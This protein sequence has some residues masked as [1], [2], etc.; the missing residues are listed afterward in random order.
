MAAHRAGRLPDGLTHRTLRHYDEIGLLTPSGRTD[1][2]Y[3]LYSRD[4]LRRLLAIQNLKSL[5]LSLTEIAAALDE[6]VDASALLGRHAAVVEDRIAEEQRLL[7]TLRRLQGAADA[8]GTRCS[9][10][11]P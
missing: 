11:S 5:G 1:V 2:D 10:R 3:R 8:G 6:G 4:D 7:A 9:P